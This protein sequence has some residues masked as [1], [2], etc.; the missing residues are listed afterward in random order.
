MRYIFI[1]CM[2]KLGFWNPK[3]K[4]VAKNGI[5]NGYYYVTNQDYVNYRKDHQ[6]GGDF[7]FRL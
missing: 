7:I 5:S 1:F 2:L 3:D 6:K 4:K